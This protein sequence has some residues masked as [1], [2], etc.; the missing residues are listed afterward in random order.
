MNTKTDFILLEKLGSLKSGSH[1]G[2]TSGA[3]VLEAASYVA[4]ELWSN[5][6]KCVSR[7]IGDFLRNWND[8]LPTD[9]DR[10]RLLKPLIPIIINTRF[11][12]WAPEE[13]RSHLALD[14]LIRTFL[15]P[16]LRLAK[17][18]HHAAA[19]A[20]LAPIVD[21]ATAAAA[22]PVVR[23]ANEA[24]L[25]VGNAAWDIMPAILV[26]DAVGEF[27]TTMDAIMAVA[28]AAMKNAIGVLWG[29]EGAWNIAEDAVWNAAWAAD[30]IAT[31]NALK[32]ARDELQA[33]AVDLVKRMAALSEAQP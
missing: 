22:G 13:Q 19:V 2:P 33:S 25:K 23:A 14:W 17:L 1:A 31:E 15:P 7:V 27:G 26:G 6:P 12:T 29:T 30:K 16:C 24:A 32:A 3:S 11:S 28:K 9:E 18:N 21:A 10:D 5:H 8:N 4:G 20:N